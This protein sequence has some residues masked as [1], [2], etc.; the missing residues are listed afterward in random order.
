VPAL[1]APFVG[2]SLGV[3]LAWAAGRELSHHSGPL[4]AARSFVVAML[5]AGLVYGPAAGYFVSFETDWAFDYLIDGARTS[6]ALVV[7]AVLLDMTSV[8]AGFAVASRAARKRR[9]FAL[10]PLVTVPNAIAAILIGL[11]ARRLSVHGTTA[12]YRRDFGLEAFAGSA[13]AYAVLFFGACLLLGTTF[14]VRQL[15]GSSGSGSKRGG[16][17]NVADEG[18]SEPGSLTG[19]LARGI[20]RGP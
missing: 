15:R 3:V 12:E 19:T 16:R 2:F 17:R 6:P 4:W 1:I 11:L 18:Q 20:G 5:Y 10:L 14:T 13:A 7:A 9:M 8:V